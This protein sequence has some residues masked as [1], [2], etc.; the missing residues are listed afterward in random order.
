MFS[1]SYISFFGPAKRDKHLSK[2]SRQYWIAYEQR[3]PFPRAHEPVLYSLYPEPQ[4]HGYTSAEAQSA[5]LVLP[6]YSANIDF[7]KESLD[8]GQLLESAD[9]V[10]PNFALAALVKICAAHVNNAEEFKDLN[11][12][13]KAAKTVEVVQGANLYN[14]E[15][16][17]SVNR[18]LKAVFGDKL[19]AQAT[20]QY[21]QA[22]K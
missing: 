13:E 5:L 15:T 19:Y 22:A 1:L 16:E 9:K 7:K 12:V 17:A 6:S 10:A 18:L 4:G 20:S 21:A 8:Y 11:K 2:F 3:R 14:A